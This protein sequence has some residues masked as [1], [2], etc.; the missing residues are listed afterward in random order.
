MNLTKQLVGDRSGNGQP[1]S[2]RSARDE[3]AERYVAVRQATEQLCRPLQTDDFQLQSM[4]QC[5]PP[6]WHL[7]HT[8]WFFETFVL[9]KYQRG[10]QPFH[11][12][13]CYLFNSYYEAVGERWPRPAR[14][15]LSRPTVAEVYEYRQSVDE[16]IRRLID[17]ADEA[18]IN[19]IDPIIELG[20]N[21]EQQHQ[22]LL[23]TDLKHAFGLNPLM[24]AYAPPISTT[25]GGDPDLVDVPGGW[26][27]LRGGVVQIGH[28]GDG[29][30]FD[31]EGPRH[32]AYVRDFEIARELV[33][34][35]QF[36][37]FMDA[38]GYERP[39]L[40]LS[41]G[42]AAR[43]ANGWS[44]PLYWKNESGHWL[45]FTLRSQRGIDPAEPLCHVSFYEADAYARWAG[46]R[47]P[48][49]SEWELAAVDQ[50]VR[51]NFLESG[52][53]HPL[54]RPDAF[55]GNAWTWTAS[56]Y[57]AY[58]GYRPP[59]GALGEYNAKFMCNQMVLR[60][61]S[62]V[63]PSDHIRATYRNFFP[64]ESRWQ[65]SGLRLARDISI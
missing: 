8:A 36:L 33:T 35:R 64:P 34:A 14:G 12:S 47:L 38:G 57:V 48:T 37:E 25:S 16:R 18:T 32:D 26:R 59:R 22:E 9:G 23:L 39:E 40:W 3:L 53:F 17:D 58:P 50:D 54:R 63:T 19:A 41:D 5:S 51:G 52:A 31:N 24:P 15:L 1:H 62:C 56:P 61:G 42:W 2:E 55:Y 43:L 30:A 45:Q 49:E 44:A 7:A 13:Y 29:F 65:F 11:P 27:R 21:H 6:K 10:Y 20:L 28:G 4:S 60:G 46:A